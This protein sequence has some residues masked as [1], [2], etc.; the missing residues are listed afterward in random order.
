MAPGIYKITNLI[1]GK[2][3]IGKSID[4]F[5]RLKVHRSVIESEKYKGGSSRPLFEDAKKFG[6]A[7]FKYEILEIF[8]GSTISEM[9]RKEVEYIFAHKSFMPQFGYNRSITADNSE[10]VYMA[11]KRRTA[12]RKAEKLASN[13]LGDFEYHEYDLSGNLIAVFRNLGALLV[14]HPGHTRQGLAQ[15]ADQISKRGTPR[16]YKGSVWKRVRREK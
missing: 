5:A 15:T 14:K 2:C 6:P 10:V 7:T 13:K 3:Y 8:D 11:R 12:V 1:N 4:V 16:V 9:G